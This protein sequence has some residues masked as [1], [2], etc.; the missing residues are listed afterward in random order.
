MFGA[1]A[2]SIFG[3]SNERYVKSLDKIVA[4]IN[5]FEPAFE[6]MSD[7]ELAGQTAKFREMLANGST[8]DQIMPEAF[9]TVREASKRVFG[10]RHFDVQMIGGMVLH[11]GEIAEMR[12]GEGKTLVATTATYLNALE[13]KGVHIVTVND[14]LARRDAE[15]M[16]KLHN[17]L[18]LTIGVIV[19]NLNEYERREAYG[20]DITYG[21]NNE[22]G[23]D[24]LR[25]NMK[26][27]RSQMVQRPSTS[28][29][30]TKWTP[31]SSTRRAPR[32]SSR[33]RPTTSRNFTCRS[34]RSLSSSSPKTTRWTRR[35]RTS[36]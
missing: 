28:R 21:T 7:E 14:Y 6:A 18:G 35:P 19:P 32:S 9:A 20:A 1:I 16:G 3:S 5:A 29:S 15:Q 27:E 34:T 13:G 8:L 23:F 25:D 17:F 10:M 24:Y 2:K 30:S 12:T 31:S 4:Q 11:R 26:H 22:F 33:A 36:I